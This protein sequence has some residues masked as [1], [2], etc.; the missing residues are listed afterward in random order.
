MALHSVVPYSLISRNSIISI[1]TLKTA[2]S[3]SQSTGLFPKLVKMAPTNAAAWLSEE[4][5]HPFEIKESP[6]G[7][8]EANE[9][10][11]RN[12]ALAINPIDGLI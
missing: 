5:K 12:H 7:K 11:I 9:I 3:V 10:L 2:S 4:K 1:Y 8:P 6:L